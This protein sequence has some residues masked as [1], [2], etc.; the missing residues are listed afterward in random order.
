MKF[1]MFQ[2]EAT[3]DISWML[4]SLG[5]SGKTILQKYLVC[6]LLTCIDKFVPTIIWRLLLLVRSPLHIHYLFA[7]HW[8]RVKSEQE[9]SGIIL[10]SSAPR[11][12]H[13]AAR[14][15]LIKM[16]KERNVCVCM[17]VYLYMHVKLAM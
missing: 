1:L 7:L 10:S 5:S 15:N 14:C 6:E 8:L 12:C 11:G 3:F 13:Q 2:E 4:E 17:C 9:S 16:G